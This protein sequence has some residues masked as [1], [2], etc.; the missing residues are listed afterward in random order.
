[1]YLVSSYNKLGV[2]QLFA[3][4]PTEESAISFIRRQ[5]G[6]MARGESAYIILT[7]EGSGEPRVYLTQRLLRCAKAP[8]WSDAMVS[9]E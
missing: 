1:M 4:F 9:T 6:K 2:R 8:D 5:I 7:E 3:G